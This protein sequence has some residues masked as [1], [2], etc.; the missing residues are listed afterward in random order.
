MNTE[1]KVIEYKIHNPE[2]PSSNL[3][4]ATKAK[5]LTSIC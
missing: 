1:N 4:L 2:V 3:G 5:T